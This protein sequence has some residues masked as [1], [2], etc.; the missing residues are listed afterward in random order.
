MGILDFDCMTTDPTSSTFYGLTN[1]QSYSTDKP[2]TY[3]SYGYN[4]VLTKSNTSPAT[5]STTSWSF[6]SS[7]SSKILSIKDGIPTTAGCAVDSRGIVTFIAVHY[8]F[9]KA[10]PYSK[11]ISAVRYDPAGVTDPALSQGTGSWSVM[12]LNPLFG[13]STFE[14]VWLHNSMVGEVETLNLAY[15][16]R[17]DVGFQP[18]IVF[19]VYDVATATFN[20]TGRWDMVSAYFQICRYMG[21]M[22]FG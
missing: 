13:Q 14:K 18:T 12:S 17:S 20:P 3:S 19:G 8:I 22:F 9:G 1:T 5:L 2:T 11:Y 6:L 4:I 7:Y 10:D 15:L 21:D 16:T